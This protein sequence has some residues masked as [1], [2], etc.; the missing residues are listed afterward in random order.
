ME[1]YYESQLEKLK[2]TKYP[3]ALKLVDEHGNITNYIDLNAESI[4]VIIE[5]LKGLQK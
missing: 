3:L 1:N 5:Y 2:P 4:P